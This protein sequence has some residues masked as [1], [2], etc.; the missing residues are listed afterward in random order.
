MIKGEVEGILQHPF[1]EVYFY[2]HNKDY[3]MMGKLDECLVKNDGKY[4]PVDHKTSS[5]DPNTRSMIPAYQTQ[6]DIYAFLL[7]Q[8][9]RPSSGIGHLIYFYPTE[10][11]KLHDGFPMQVTVKTLKTNTENAKKEFIKAITVLDDPM[12]KP[13]KK[14]AFCTWQQD[15]KQYIK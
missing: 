12:P 8:N 15:I 11:D 2:H 13:S 1:Q 3:G 9:Q 10:G 6:L 4:T 14:C 5:S 7:E